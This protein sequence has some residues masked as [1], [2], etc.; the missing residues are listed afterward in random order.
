MLAA[1]GSRVVAWLQEE[2]ATVW[3]SAWAR[4]VLYTMN[5]RLLFVLGF[6]G[7]RV[8]TMSRDLS[9]LLSPR[10]VAVVGASSR[11]GSVAGEILRNILRC[12][13]HGIVYPVNPKHDTVEGLPCY[14]SVDD[15]PRKVDLAILAI[16]KDLVLGLVNQCGDR[17]ITNLVIITS[18][19]NENKPSNHSAASF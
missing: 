16:N 17:G 15:L 1:V 10:S 19:Y 8:N 9:R 14:A 7:W 6:V 2:P 12:G 18:G 11:P 4:R 5:L 13:Y 3:R